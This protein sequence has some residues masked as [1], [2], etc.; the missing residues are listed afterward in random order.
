[1]LFSSSHLLCLLSILP[2]LHT[3]PDKGSVGRSA[4]CLAEG[5][6]GYYSV[7]HVLTGGAGANCRV[8]R[9][10]I[11]KIWR[12]R[13]SENANDYMACL[14]QFLFSRLFWFLPCYFILVKPSAITLT[15]W[16]ILYLRVGEGPGVCMGVAGMN[17]SWMLSLLIKDVSMWRRSGWI[18]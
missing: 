16:Q 11:A 18:G 2:F 14:P 15:Q 17:K 13:M 4:A 8:R 12:R 10:S 9:K 1:M 5:F 7:V 3:G 6:Q